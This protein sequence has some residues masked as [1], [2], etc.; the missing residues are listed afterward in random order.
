MATPSFFF[1]FVLLLAADLVSLSISQATNATCSPPPQPSSA[2]PIDPNDT[3]QIQF[4]L[5]L[6]HLEAE[7]FLFGALGRGLDSVAPQLAQGGPPPVGAQKANLDDLTRRIIEEFGYQEVGH[8]RAIKSTVN[9][10]PRPL[11]D[12]SSGSFAKLFDQAFGYNLDPPF[13][14]Y[15]STVNFL[16]A[17]YI[18]PYVGL[19]AYVGTAPNLNGYVSK[20]LVASLLGVEAGQDAVIRTL[21][22]ERADECVKPYNN[23]VAEFTNRISDLRNR[24]A[25]CGI[26]DEGIIVPLEL[27][28][29]NKTTS[30]ILSADANSLSYARIPAEILRIVYGTGSEYKPGGFLP[31]GGNGKVARDFLN[32]S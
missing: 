7:L 12:L 6:E 10:F 32:Q 3:D 5:N 19:V 1:F 20:G 15:F 14:P 11:L 22:Y 24:L 25:M 28:A 30:N 9:G 31:N 13:D 26:K 2:V 8:L 4:A 29:E 21:L 17:S 18:V 16:L 23:T 27:G